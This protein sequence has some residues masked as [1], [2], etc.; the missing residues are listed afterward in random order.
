MDVL[1]S[2]FLFS[3]LFLSYKLIS[4]AGDTLIGPHL[5]LKIVLH[6]GPTPGL[7]ICLHFF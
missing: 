6:P 7:K 2:A 3:F 1:N 5:G 4:Y